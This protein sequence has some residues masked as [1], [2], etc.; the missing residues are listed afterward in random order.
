VKNLALMTHVTTDEEEEPLRRLAFGVAHSTPRIQA[1]LRPFLAALGTEPL[2]L[3]GGGQLGAPGTA[4]VFLNGHVLG[5]HRWPLRLAQRLRALRRSGRLGEFVSV[6]AIGKRC[7]I[8]SDGG[9]VCRPLIIVENGVPKVTDAHLTELKEGRLAFVD[10]IE[11]GLV[12]YLDVNEENDSLIALMLSNITL[13][14]THME[15]E[16]FTI[17]GVVAG[18]IPYPHHNQSP[19]NTYQCAMGKQAMGAVAFNQN[20]SRRAP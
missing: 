18:L 15:I 5:A 7:Y 2:L 14:T 4:L 11:K 8:A 3:L 10:F 16:P 17:L 19:R 6:H 12:E 9:R 13:Q 1:S 20:V